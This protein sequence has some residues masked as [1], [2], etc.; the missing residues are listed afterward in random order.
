MDMKIMYIERQLGC[1]G[2]K[3]EGLRAGQGRTAGPLVRRYST[4]GTSTIRMIRCQTLRILKSM[5]RQNLILE[6]SLLQGFH[7]FHTFKEKKS[8]YGS[9]RNYAVPLENPWVKKT[10]LKR[11]FP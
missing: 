9:K 10:E 7:N 2:A 3:K 8:G 11:R 1:W 4:R 6:A 5:K